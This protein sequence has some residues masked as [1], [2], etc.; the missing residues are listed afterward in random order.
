MH[1]ES[2]IETKTNEIKEIKRRIA[3]AHKCRPNWN[4]RVAF[5]ARTFNCTVF[6]HRRRHAHVSP[7]PNSTQELCG[8]RWCWCIWKAST[9]HTLRLFECICLQTK[10]AGDSEQYFSWKLNLRKM[11]EKIIERHGNNSSEQKRNECVERIMKCNKRNGIVEFGQQ[12]RKRRR[13]QLAHILMS[14]RRRTCV[15]I[16][17]V[18]RNTIFSSLQFSHRHHHH[19][20]AFVHSMDLSAN[21]II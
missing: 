2:R 7:Q 21:A 16:F 9:I 20:S 11:R 10:Y 17:H 5:N 18:P 8:C 14:T 15:R 1:S 13:P 19:H 12:G 4:T 3:W 6:T